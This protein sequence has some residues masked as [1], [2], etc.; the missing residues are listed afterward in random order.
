MELKRQKTYKGVFEK[1]C[2]DILHGMDIEENLFRAGLKCEKIDNILKI[3]VPFFDELITL[4]LPSF[5]FISSRETNITLVT[6]IIILH[7]INTASGTPLTGERVAYGDI[8]A[9]MHYDPVYERRVLKPLVRAFGFDKYA[10]R[11]AGQSL[12]AKDEEFG[13]AAFTLFAFPKVPITF[14]IWEGDE[15]FAPRARAL[16][17]PSVTGYLPLEDI[18]VISKLASGRILKAA[19][20]N[21]SED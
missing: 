6:R 2:S 18:V 15:E 12:Q 16:F 21:I 17:D 9:C 3:S 5:T 19:M 10:F 13:D 20:K 8:P 11:E 4:T 7:Y 14:I 1:A